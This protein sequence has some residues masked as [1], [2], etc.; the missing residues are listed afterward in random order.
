[1]DYKNQIIYFVVDYYETLEIIGL[2][3]YKKD[4]GL[5]IYDLISLKNGFSH[6]DLTVYNYLNTNN[7]DQNVQ[8]KFKQLNATGRDE[9][10]KWGFYEQENELLEK[11]FEE[12]VLSAKMLPILSL[13][14]KEKKVAILNGFLKKYGPVSPAKTYYELLLAKELDQ[15]KKPYIASL[16]NLIGE[17]QKLEVFFGSK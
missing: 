14:K 6:S 5:G 11:H 8:D 12:L 13:F 1:M 7:S 17:S 3:V 9:I 10:L 4:N 16:K 15:D 2:M